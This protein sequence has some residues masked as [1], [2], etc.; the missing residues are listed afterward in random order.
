MGPTPNAVHSHPR[1]GSAFE[2]AAIVSPC[3]VSLTGAGVGRGWGREGCT[4]TC[5]YINSDCD[6]P[7]P[8]KKE[9][10]KKVGELSAVHIMTP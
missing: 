5:R 10:K 3:A 1:N 6:P 4:V 2:W 9:R 8:K 7:P